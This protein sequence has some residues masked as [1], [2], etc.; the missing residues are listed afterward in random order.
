MDIKIIQNYNLQM[1]KIFSSFCNNHNI[2]FFLDSG[3]LLGAI[4][5]KGFIPWDDDIDISM[6]RE[7]FNKLND[8]LHK[9][10]IDEK[11]V[12][13]SAFDISK[14]DF[15]D[16]VPRLFYK[17]EII[18]D[19]EKYKFM[20]SGFF[21]YPHIDIFIID[22]VKINKIKISQLMQKI[23]YGLAMGHRKN[24]QYEKYNILEKVEVIFLSFIGRLIPLKYIF[25]MQKKF[26]TRYMPQN[27]N[28][29]EKYYYYSNYEPA[30]QYMH[31]KKEWIEEYIEVPFE[32]MKI[33]IPSGFDEI[34]KKLYGNYLQLPPIEQRVATHKEMF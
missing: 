31:L 11:I 2:K 9:N 13:K 1:L 12:Y 27:E 8:M 3:S 16:F 5:H 15:F 25:K 4:R 34:L 24:I 18:R 33:H 20:H 21:Q 30:W 7:N 19:S 32:D 22:E 14:D 29:K 26:A 17:K 28:D 23:I 6:T 10:I